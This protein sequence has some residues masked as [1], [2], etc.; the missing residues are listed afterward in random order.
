[1]N[2]VLKY[3]VFKSS[4]ES[5]DKLF[6]KASEFATRIG[7]ENLENISVSCCGSDQGVVTVW[8]WEEN[9]PGQM[10]EINQVNFG[11]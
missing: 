3:E 1:M 11:E 4:W 9:G 2:S 6:A 5:W 7:R 10:F 8:Y